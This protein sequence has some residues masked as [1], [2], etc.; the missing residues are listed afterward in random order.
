MEKSMATSKTTVSTIEKSLSGIVGK[1]NIETDPKVL[2]KYACDSSLLPPHMPDMKVKVKNTGQVQK[3]L[4]I[5]NENHYPVVPRSS[6]TGS[7]GTGIPSEGG[8]ILDLSDM[9]RIP[10]IDKR[11]RW[12][13]LEPGVTWGQ[14]QDKLAKEGMQAFNPLLPRKDKSVITS[15]LEKEPGL[16]PKTTTDET[17]RTM[18]FVWASGELFRTG[19]MSVSTIPAEKIPDETKSDLSSIGGPGL[20]WWRLLTGAQGSFGVIT[21]MN[22]KIL[23]TPLMQK[24]IFIPFTELEEAILPLYSIQ[25]REIGNEC[26]LLNNHNLASI[27]AEKDSEISEL[28]ERCPAFCIVLNLSGGQ[29]FPE[30]RIAYEQDALLDIGKQYNFTPCET[31]P[32]VPEADKRFQDM[33]TH[34]WEGDTYWKDRFHGACLDIIFLSG[35]DSVP[36]YWN[37]LE[38]VTATHGLNANN[39]GLYIQPKQ[40]ARVSHVEFNIPCDPDNENSIENVKTFHQKASE[41]L[42]NAGAYFYRPYYNWD[43]MIYSRTGYVHETTRK[44]KSILDP[45]RILNPG[46]LNL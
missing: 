27:L 4:K 12:V 9:K 37:L 28:K 10:R 26:F 44:L 1:K 5:A 18:E 22:I 23:H 34:P 38:Q 30:E 39:F 31:L 25:R 46:K 36:S 17:I 7:Y 14:L 35:L 40:R 33:L 13:L 21:I 16:I 29:F 42:M 3:V 24:V 6:L 20:D 45:N 15:T 11:N 32:G 41:T 8:V 2:S 43:H 19:A